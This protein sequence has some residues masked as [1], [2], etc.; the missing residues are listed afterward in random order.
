M[1]TIPCFALLG[2]GTLLNFDE[3]GSD[4][5]SKYR[6]VC[7]NLASGVVDAGMSTNVANSSD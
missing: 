4:I 1:C 6:W 3:R 5:T 2:F 7:E